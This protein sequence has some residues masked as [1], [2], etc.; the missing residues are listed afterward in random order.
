PTPG[1]PPAGPFGGGPAIELSMRRK[2][3][4]LVAILVGLFLAALDQTIVG[5]AL[6][7]IVGD[8]RGTN[9]LYTWVITIYL[10]TSTISG[11]FYGKLSDLYG[12]RPMLLIGVSLF[13]LGSFLCGLSW[14][15]ESLIAFRG[16]QGLGAGAL[17]PISLAV[18]GDLFT[19]AERGKYQGLF[20]AVFG[21]AAIVGPLLGGWLTDT[22]GWHWIFFVNLPVGF[23]ALA[24]IWRTLPPLRREGV[25]YSLDYLGA[26]VFTVAISFLLIGLTNKQSGDW[27]D[28]GVGGFIVVGLIVG[29]LFLLV[30]SRAKEPIVPLTLFRNRV[31]AVSIA[32]V[33]LAGSGFFAAVVFLP[34]WFQFVKGVSPTESGFQTL[35]LLV[36][37]IGSSIVSGAVISRTGRYKRLIV[38]SL[39]L[40][41]LGLF[42]MTHLSATTDVPM[43][44]LWMLITGVGTGPTLAAF[45]IVVQSAVPLHQLG[46]ATSNLTFFRQVGGSVGLAIVGTLFGQVL[47]DAVAPSLLRQ[48]IPV[49]L[50]SRLAG[51][52]GGGG[53]GEVGGVGQDLRATLETTLPA[54]LRPF[55]D[56]IVTGVFDAFSQ[57]VAATF[58][59]GVVTAGAALLVALLLPEIPLRGVRGPHHRDGA[60]AE[61]PGA[62]AAP[63]ALGH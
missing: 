44:W 28:V 61:G 34:R 12:R 4:I 22:V 38:G 49:E 6:P 19:P 7:R 48:G 35:A 56:G 9:E 40:M 31:Y 8:L 55:I 59:V 57:A 2:K 54:D 26:A 15:M 25:R 60:A 20:G 41:C 1:G 52:A 63:A 16:I 33:F 32:A 53:G 3:E 10:L 50:A 5:T 58:W 42:L 51:F 14:S 37:V 17:F 39:A 29:A 30:E 24:I 36:G 18:I 46:V 45:T 11:V 21:V 23:L 47:A 43:L 13:L 62:P 27:A